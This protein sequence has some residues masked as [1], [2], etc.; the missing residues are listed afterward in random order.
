MPGLE[1][2]WLTALTHAPRER[3][4]RYKARRKKHGT[5]RV[6]TQKYDTRN[7]MSREIIS[8]SLQLHRFLKTKE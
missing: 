3:A 2:L 6:S 1:E 7:N 4:N 5:S 8:D